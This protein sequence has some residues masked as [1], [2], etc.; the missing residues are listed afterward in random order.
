MDRF[1][2]L[3]PGQ[4]RAPLPPGFTVKATTKDT[5]GRVVV[6]ENQLNIDVPEHV[7]ERMDELVYV[8]EG[9]MEID[10]RGETHRLSKGMFAVV[11]M[12]I[13]H[14][15]RNVSDP[16]VRA[17]QISSPG[18]WDEFLRDMFGAGPALRTEDGQMDLA[19][20]NEIGEKYGMRYTSAAMGL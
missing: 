12:G 18:G 3:Q 15:M 7:H 9:E 6:M 2:V 16:P 1:V 11:P 4:T 8:L 5:E 20:V 13:P 14:A 10:F 17:L 19:K